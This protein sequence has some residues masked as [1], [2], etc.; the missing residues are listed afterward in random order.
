MA[1]VALHIV[2]RP[3]N[4]FL[5]MPSNPDSTSAQPGDKPQVREGC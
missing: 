1:K 2:S 3:S 5:D 4:V